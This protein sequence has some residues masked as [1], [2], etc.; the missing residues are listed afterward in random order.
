MSA[1]E[2]RSRLDHPVLDADGHMI[3][4]LPLLRQFIVEEAGES[5]AAN[6]DDFVFGT[7]DK[8]VV[9]EKRREM[10]VT[11]KAWWGYPAENTLDRATAM[12]PELMYK[13]LD[14]F[15]IDYAI[16]Y[17]T[18]GLFPSS[19]VDDE[20]R[21][22]LTRSVNRYYSEVCCDH[23]DRFEPVAAIPMRTPDEAIAELNFVAERGLKAVV[24]AGIVQRPLKGAE[25]VPGAFWIDTVAHDSIYD[26]DPVWQRCVDLGISPTFHAIGS[27]WG[28]RTSSTNFVFN[29]IG[30]FATAQEAACRSIVMG[31][32]AKRFPELRFSF[33]EG[34]VAWAANLCSDLI[35]HFEKRNVESVQTLNPDKID[36]RLLMELAENHGSPKVVALLGQLDY[37][38][39]NLFGID[40]LDADEVD[41]FAQA[42]IGTPDDIVELFTDHFY[43]GCEADDPMT[44]VAFDKNLPP[45]GHDLHPIFASDI[46]HFDVPDAAGVLEEAWELV[47]FEQLNM[48]QFKTFMF[49]NAAQLWSAQNPKFFE[50]T[51]IADEVRD[52]NN[53]S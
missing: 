22:A 17:P 16:V 9:R 45:Y 44:A 47:K 50:G 48:E 34:G 53:E 33:L 8:S 3:E 26:Y 49:S 5:V 21:L 13:R 51:A 28:T 10:R 41:E 25:G 38:L 29:H 37:S 6:F 32:V 18:F 12:F 31:G 36:R 4:Y 15:G 11:R 20:L 30:H 24:M 42:Q 39:N 27:G 19:V 35:G 2:V 23:R 40:E 1:E 46:G 14:E 43:F 7:S 52:L